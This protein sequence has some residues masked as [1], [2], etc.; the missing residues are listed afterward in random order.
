M[1]MEGVKINPRKIVKEVNSMKKIAVAMLITITLIISSAP[2]FGHD[3]DMEITMD[4]L[5]VRP[6]GL[7][8]IVVGAAV[9][10]VALPIA[11]SSR[12]VGTTAQALVVSPCKYTFVRPI[13]DFSAKWDSGNPVGRQP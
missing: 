3:Q 8:A 11:V 1:Q 7:A 4:V 5:I 6:A 13:G 10:I 9:F 2:A 12:S